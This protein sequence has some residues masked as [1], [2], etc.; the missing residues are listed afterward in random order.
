V[1]QGL[2]LFKYL[3]NFSGFSPR[4]TTIRIICDAGG[5]RKGIVILDPMCCAVLCCIVYCFAMSN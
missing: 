3:F 4:E 1:G 2:G 5:K